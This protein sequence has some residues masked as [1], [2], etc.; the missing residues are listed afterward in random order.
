MEK[1]RKDHSKEMDTLRRAKDEII[2]DLKGTNHTLQSQMVGPKS[3]CTTYDGN[4]TPFEENMAIQCDLDGTPTLKELPPKPKQKG[5]ARSRQNSD[6]E[7]VRNNLPLD[8]CC[9][10]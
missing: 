8:D 4:D 10:L 7:V 1:D 9:F 6:N 5:R 2:A 3:S